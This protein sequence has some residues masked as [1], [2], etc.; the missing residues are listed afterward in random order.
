MYLPVSY[1]LSCIV[2]LWYPTYNDTRHTMIPDIEGMQPDI[3][4][5]TQGS[6]TASR[7]AQDVRNRASDQLLIPWLSLGRFSCLFSLF[8]LCIEG[9]QADI[10]SYKQGSKTASRLAQDMHNRASDQLHIPW[11]SLGRFNCLVANMLVYTS[12]LSHFLSCIET[13]SASKSRDDIAVCQT[14]PHNITNYYKSASKRRDDIT[15]CQ[16]QPHNITNYYNLP[17]Y[18]FFLLLLFFY[19][20]LYNNAEQ[21]LISTSYSLVIPWS[22]LLFSRKLVT[23]YISAI[24]SYHVSRHFE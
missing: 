10:Q 16:T 2:T 4:W 14:Q 17:L 12:R 24:I 21:S 8:I 19:Y 22:L 20:C 6:K 15:V 18:Y 3:Q 1:I 11:L 7:L 13:R 5:Y 9:M 23:L